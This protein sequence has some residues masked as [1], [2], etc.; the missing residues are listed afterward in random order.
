MSDSS[1]FLFVDAS[2]Y[3][4]FFF[5]FFFFFFLF[6]Y[7]FFSLFF[8]LG[9]LFWLLIGYCLCWAHGRGGL[10]FFLACG[11]DGFTQCLLLW[12]E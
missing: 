2:G 1:V 12:H 5:L 4:L 6:I 8:I 10:F 9:F 7:F 11:M 3:L